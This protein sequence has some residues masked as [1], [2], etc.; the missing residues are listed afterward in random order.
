[1]LYQRLFFTLNALLGSIWLSGQCIGVQNCPIV[2][3][4]MPICVTTN[5]Q[6]TLWNHPVFYNPVTGT[7]NLFEGEAPLSV[8]VLYTPNYS[9]PI[10]TRF[11]LFWIWME[12]AVGKLSYKVG[13]F[14][15]QAL[16]YSKILPTLKTVG[17]LLVTTTDR[18]H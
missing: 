4:T 17:P 7:N 16:S 3:D 1:M 10:D 9:A 8:N 6:S 11:E 18:S 15:Q 2:Q 5:D 13:R 12:T 14:H